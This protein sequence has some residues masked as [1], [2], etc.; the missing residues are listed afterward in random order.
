[1]LFEFKEDMC[2]WLNRFDSLG[3]PVTLNLNKEGT[4]TSRIGG[5]LSLLAIIITLLVTVEEA[6]KLSLTTNFNVAESFEILDSN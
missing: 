5:L 4:S 3:V 1:M 6:Y 2:F